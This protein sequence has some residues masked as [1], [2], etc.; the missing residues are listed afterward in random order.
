MTP[1]LVMASPPSR[2]RN[3]TLPSTPN[4]RFDY[5]EIEIS[6]KSDIITVH[7]FEQFYSLFFWRSEIIVYEFIFPSIPHDTYGPTRI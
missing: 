2:L 6:V 3:P 4:T 1:P 5:I 7:P